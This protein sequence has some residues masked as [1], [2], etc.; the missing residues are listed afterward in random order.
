ML[1]LRRLM[2]FER[3]QFLVKIC[4]AHRNARSAQEEGGE[5]RRHLVLI[6][7]VVVVVAVEVH[8]IMLVSQLHF[9]LQ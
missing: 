1:L 3:A 7:V 8:Q 2:H 5:D 6:V 4:E 9:D